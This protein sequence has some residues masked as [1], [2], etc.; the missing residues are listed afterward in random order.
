M[1]KPPYR[2]APTS[3]PGMPPGIPYIVGN[4]AAERFSFYGM[5]TILVVFMTKYL[6]LMGS[7]AG[8]PMS[9]AKAT[10]YFHLFVAAV[11]LTP[12]FGAILSDAWLGKY[13]T[14]VWLSLGYCVG[15][16]LLAMMGAFGNAALFLFFG[17]AWI[18]VGA[19]GIKSCVSAHVGDQF[20]KSNSHLLTKIYN[21]FYWS[22]NLGAF[23]STML[24]PW[25]LHWY[26]PHWAFGVPGVL[27]AIA[28]LVFWLGRWKFIHVP[29]KGES[30]VKEAFSRQGLLAFGK[31]C[32]VLV[33]ITMFWALFDQT[34]SSWVLQA[35][36]M[37]LNFLGIEWL[38]SQV[39]AIN[40]ILVLLFI[41]LFTLVIYPAIDRV[42]RLTA[43]RKMAIGFFV[44]VAGFAIVAIA[45]QRIDAGAT[46]SVGWQ[47]LAFFLVT[48]SEIMVSIVGLEFSY[49]QAPKTMKSL[50]M[51]V[52]FF[53][54][55]LGN[56]L[57]AGVNNAIQVPDPF[58]D[59]E[60]PASQVEPVVHPGHD[61]AEGTLDDIIVHFADGKRGKIEF[62][63]L[64]TITEAA[65]RIEA[66]I[67]AN[68]WS[69]P[70][71][72]S[73]Q[74]LLDGLTDPWGN[75]LRYSL[76]TRN[77]CRVTSDGPDK[78]PVTRWDQGVVLEIAIPEPVKEQGWMSA[79]QP[80][81]DWLTR[82]QRELNLKNAV[83]PEAEPDGPSVS[84]RYFVG[85]QTRLEGAPYFWFFTLLM[86]VT[87][88]G[89]LVVAKFYKPV[90]YFHD[91]AP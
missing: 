3:T 15:H 35:Q 40:P 27:M 44:M 72:D 66:A 16:G 53:T 19:G 62:A 47:F 1:A 2:T 41:P 67:A 29:A 39:Q 38:P 43:M 80:E 57:T 58:A 36:D 60:I 33:F 49:T 68:D 34:G 32:V 6:F 25:L 88:T 50:V 20:G 51:G 91:E 23:F 74:Q 10:E 11:Y 22:I 86:A 54:V 17:L 52:F 75:P 26:G 69:N 5:R 21:Y 87:A 76:I 14:I 9:N 65:T 59:L 77:L 64:D 46:P 8:E 61:E 85:G 89:F 63:G 79:F 37:N 55:F 90:E 83:E 78:A 24:T 73:G 48:A 12:F 45:Q 18:T 81:E 4:E 70:S 42:F 82:R 7:T 28:T 31:L 56:F 30:F 84:R 13:R 71:A